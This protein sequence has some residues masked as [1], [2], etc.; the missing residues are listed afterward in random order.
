MAEKGVEVM[1]LMLFE[2]KGTAVTAVTVGMEMMATSSNSEVVTG[3]AL[4]GAM[5]VEPSEGL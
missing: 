5:G 4:P 1:G 2:A 3:T